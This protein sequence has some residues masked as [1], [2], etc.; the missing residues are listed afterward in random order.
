[1]PSRVLKQKLVKPRKITQVKFNKIIFTDFLKAIKKGDTKTLRQAKKQHYK[2]NIYWLI[3]NHKKVSKK[4]MDYLLK[5]GMVN[6]STKNL[7]KLLEKM[8]M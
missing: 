5:N 6:K 8:K 2:I 7:N 4:T 1:M 3:E